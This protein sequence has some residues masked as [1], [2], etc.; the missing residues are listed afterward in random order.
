ML[1]SKSLNSAAVAPATYP[2]DVNS[3]HVGEH[4]TALVALSHSTTEQQIYGAM[5]AEGFVAFIA[6]VTKAS[7]LVS[8]TTSIARFSWFSHRWRSIRAGHSRI[9][10][11]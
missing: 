4:A 9:F 6:L 5:L 8:T 11:T 10:P 1:V 7:A 2:F 3:E